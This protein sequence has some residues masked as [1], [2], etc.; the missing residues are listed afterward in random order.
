MTTQVPFPTLGQ[1]GY[2]IPEDS[3][4]LAGVCADINAAF[5]GNLNILGSANQTTSWMNTPQGQL[6]A[7]MTDVISKCFALFLSY[8]SQ[9]DPQYS[10]GIMQDGLGNLYSQTRFQ[11]TPTTITCQVNGLAGTV[12]PTGGPVLTDAGGSLYVATSS[13]TI[14]SNATTVVFA[15]Q[16]TGPIPVIGALSI[17]QTTP[18]WDS[19]QAPSAT[20]LGQ[21]VESQQQFELRRQNSVAGNAVGINDAV[22]AAVLASGQNINQT[23]TGAYVVDNPTSVAVPIVVG[24]NTPMNTVTLQPNS[25][26]V[27]VVGGNQSAIAQA[28]ATKKGG[29]CA[30]S[31]SA[32]FVGN[33]SGT[34]LTITS[35]I[36]GIVAINQNVLA[37]P[38]ALIAMPSGIYIQSNGTG[39]G[40]VGTYNL[41]ATAPTATGVSM[42]SATVTLVPDASYPSNPPIYTV[43]Y[44]QAIPTL[45][46]ITVALAAAS[47]PPSNALS[48]LQAATGL[49]QAF[50]GADGLAPLDA[51]IGGAVY[52]SRFYPTIAQIL[53][54]IA[55]VNVQVGTGA[56][57]GNSVA[58]NINQTPALGVITLIL[59]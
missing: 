13:V 11:A 34:L 31:P 5:G 19:V 3:D 33:V 26:Y 7:S 42:T 8:V 28:I 53:P 39:T 30:Y 10:Q 16:Q 29:G 55:V 36:S 35:M 56:T 48:L 45:I 27:A 22:L 52:A 20:T 49:A 2:V 15:N 58:L 25:I 1:S 32:T 4:I 9:T 23:P 41:S 54:G 38:G 18:G 37:A 47:N 6:A 51:Q 17:Y 57:S 21:N 46:N 50:T 40:G 14:G 59:T 12:V 44:T 43:Q 24:A